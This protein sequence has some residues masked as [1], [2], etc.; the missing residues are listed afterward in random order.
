MDPLGCM[1]DAL[2]D[3]IA[4]T[5]RN[6][7]RALLELRDGQRIGQEG[8]I[9][10]YQFMLTG[11]AQLRDDTPV[12]VSV[13]TLRASGSVV[14]V[15]EGLV[16]VALE[17]D[18]GPSIAA[19]VLEADATFLLERLRERLREIKS[20]GRRFER[21]A[22]ER[23]LG[24]RQATVTR[25]DPVPVVLQGL[26]SDQCQAVRQAFGSDAT[27]VWGPPGTGKTRTIAHTVEA[28]FRAGRTVLLVSNT[29]IAVDTALER[30][31]E[32][33]ENAPEFHLGS[34]IRLGTVVKNEL[35]NRYGEMVALDRVVARLSDELQHK[36]DACHAELSDLE[37][38]RELL[39]TQQETLRQYEGTRARLTEK[40]LERERLQKDYQHAIRERQGYETRLARVTDD[41]ARAQSMNV[42]RRLLSGLDPQRLQRQKAELEQAVARATAEQTGYEAAIEQLEREIGSLQREVDRQARETAHLPSLSIVTKQLEAIDARAGEIREQLAAIEQEFAKLGQRLLNDCRVLA[43]T[44]YQ[45]YLPRFPERQFDVVVIDEASMLMPPLV[46]YVAGLATRAIVIAGDFRQLPPIVQAKTELAR[47]WLARDAFELA[48]I[49][50]RVEAGNR[51]L[52]LVLLS[53]QYRM[54]PAICA[55]VN[56][57]FYGGQLRSDDSVKNRPSSFPL[58]AAPIFLV[59]TA[60][61]EPW[62]A[63]R[64]GT[65]SRYNILHAVL[66][67]NLVR[68]LVETGFLSL[69][70]QEQD[71]LGIVSPYHAQARLIE[72][73]LIAEYGSKASGIA[74]TVHRFQGNEKRA[75][76]IDVTDS[77]P[78]PLGQFFRACHVQEEGARLLNVAMS[79]AREHIVLVGNLAYLRSKV[80]GHFVLHR[81]IEGL[82]AEGEPL[83]A[84]SLLGL[85]PLGQSTRLGR[86]T[87]PGELRVASETVVDHE[88]FVQLFTQDIQHARE[89]IVLLSPF[90]APQA[91]QRW[92]EPLARAVKRGVRIRVI[93]RAG[94]SRRLDEVIHQLRAH[95]IS[96]DLWEQMHEKVVIIDDKIVWYGSMNVLQHRLSTEL[97]IRSSDQSLCRAIVSM[98]AGVTGEARAFDALANPLCSVCGGQMVRRSQKRSY[99]C[100]TPGCPGGLGQR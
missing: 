35:R 70:D 34:V 92:I 18:L 56:E 74:A 57:L 61:L 22:A 36:K 93:T 29:N 95:G 40:Q 23:A 54:H 51:P 83:S 94:Q 13:G 42:L 37:G 77:Q 98:L 75:I 8:A 86:E 82:L 72:T 78:L 21:A 6:G 7:R 53:T 2:D 12:Q 68:T 84:K 25:G 17:Q 62:A 33:L 32:R 67:R 31:A 90:I 91:L 87:G 38:E 64:A 47:E 30:V 5:R 11:E 15:R 1:L 14:S 9:W 50:A 85:S 89:S 43:T 58:G 20:G 59:D 55:L 80:D 46:Y 41:L 16:I 69:A 71:A 81:L 49:P 48:G 44:V 100:T 79:R 19:A 76:V 28:F 60:A 66:V 96:V 63:Y 52:N 88:G 10:L 27:F 24:L 3:E 39:L 99:M 26:N 97:M 65:F 4:A 45:T 73:L